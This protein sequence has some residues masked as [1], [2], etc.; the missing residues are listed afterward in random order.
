MCSTLHNWGNSRYNASQSS[1][2][3][4][5][6]K[7][8]QLHWDPVK[9]SKIDLKRVVL[10]STQ[11]RK[12]NCVLYAYYIIWFNG[13]C[14]DMKC[15][16]SACGIVGLK[17]NSRNYDC[18]FKGRSKTHP[19]FFL[20]HSVAFTSSFCIIPDTTRVTS[21]LAVGFISYEYILAINFHY[22]ALCMHFRYCKKKLHTTK[23]RMDLNYTPSEYCT[24]NSNSFSYQ[25]HIK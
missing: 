22:F 19:L 21:G 11:P 10:I 24:F 13:Y 4:I 8:A 6:V 9:T 1:K 14:F 12:Y 25:F 2:H 3:S 20:S 16:V 17:Y 15:F 18:A 23:C 7:L 5:S